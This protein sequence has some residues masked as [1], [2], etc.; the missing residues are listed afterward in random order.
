MAITQQVLQS[1][2]LQRRPDDRNNDTVHL[3]GTH[4]GKQKK[5]GCC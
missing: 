2:K 4:G 3:G 1:K 5:K